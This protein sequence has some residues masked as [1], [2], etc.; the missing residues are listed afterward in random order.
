MGHPHGL[1]FSEW[2]N[3]KGYSNQLLSRCRSSGWLE[4]LTRGV[5]Y[6]KGVDLLDTSKIDLGNSKYQ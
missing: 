3:K 6:R 2:L 5:M 4:S 1:Y